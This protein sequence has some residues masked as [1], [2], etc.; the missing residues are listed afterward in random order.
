MQ[1]RDDGRMVGRVTID[2]RH[3]DLHWILR[4]AAGLAQ[5]D[6][7]H[8]A[9]L[10]TLC[11]VDAF[12]VRDARNCGMKPGRGVRDR[13][14][15]FLRKR[16]PAHTRVEDFNI[17]VPAAGRLLRLEEIVYQ[18]LRN[19]VVHEGAQ[20]DAAPGVATAIDW[21]DG[22][23]SVL[24]NGRHAIL[25]GRWLLQCLLGL[26]QDEM[27]RHLVIGGILAAICRQPRRAPLN[28]TD[29]TS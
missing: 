7:Q 9:L 12:S 20:L 26:V 5:L 25:G 19:P 15:R 1:R 4:D 17:W 28:G 24:V 23:P 18:Y 29:A 2:L 14:S 8:S 13:Y 3:H 22:A 10:L 6:H 27:A 16:L 11:A 21:R